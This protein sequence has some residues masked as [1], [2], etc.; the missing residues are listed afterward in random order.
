MVSTFGDRFAAVW[1]FS[2]PWWGGRNVALGTKENIKAK[3]LTAFVKLTDAVKSQ[4]TLDS[5]Y[6]GHREGKECWWGVWNVAE[7]T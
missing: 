6:C 3:L 5:D 1:L 7:L 2:L 4:V